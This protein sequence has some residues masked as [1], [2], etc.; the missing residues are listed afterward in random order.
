MK[1]S[2]YDRYLVYFSRDVLID[3]RAQPDKFEIKEDDYGGELENRNIDFNSINNNWYRVRYGFRK[4]DD[5]SVCIAA[6]LPDLSK[7]PFQIRRR[8]KIYELNEPN[9]A[10]DDEAF[11]DWV[12][13]YLEGSWGYKTRP[14]ADTY[15]QIKLINSIT[16]QLFSKALFN[17][18]ENPLLNYPEADNTESYKKAHLEL[19]RLIIDGLNKTTIEILADQLNVS[20]T[21]STK[22]LNSLT[23]ILPP[24]KIAQIYNPIRDCNKTRQKLHG[25]PSTKPESFPAFLTFKDDLFNIG[26]A[27]KE[28]THWLE[29]A[30]NVDSESCLR[31][32]EMKTLFPKLTLPENLLPMFDEIKQ[33]ESKTIEKIEYGIEKSVPGKHDS[34]GLII[35]FND[36]TSISILIGSNAGNLSME[37]EDFK[38]NDFKTDLNFFWAPS[39]KKG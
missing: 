30:F 36:G 12:Q 25:I 31:R 35:H 3:Y 19:Y 38:P 15:R 11:K 7:L 29:E 20:L 34:E 17:K 26:Q 14:K 9:F 39:I 13:Q 10:E 1:H 4:L 23:E 16:L 32:E 6:F 33:A 5:N 18:D 22:T 21:D 27:L 28:L 37:H 8:W 2:E 24:N